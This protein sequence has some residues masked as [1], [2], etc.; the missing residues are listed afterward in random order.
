MADIA[1]VSRG[2]NKVRTIGQAKV[3]IGEALSEIGRAFT[4]LRRGRSLLFGDQTRAGR[5]ALEAARIPL[6]EWFSEIKNLPD[7]TEYRDQFRKRRN[8]VTRAYVEVAGVVGELR[9][10]RTVSLGEELARSAGQLAD[11]AGTVGKSLS[12]ILA[13]FLK[14]LIPIIVVIVAVIV[15]VK[16]GPKLKKA[17]T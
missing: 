5:N 17:S 9:A 7:S 1:Q 2:L 16:F 12:E 6:Q 4:A 3:A 11:K 10:R 8:L 14:P 13:A 15:F